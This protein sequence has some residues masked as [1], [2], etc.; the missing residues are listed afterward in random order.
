MIL[1][2]YTN[3]Q[4]AFRPIAMCLVHHRF[5]YIFTEAQHTFMLFIHAALHT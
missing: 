2:I 4:A 1:N 3:V 5:V